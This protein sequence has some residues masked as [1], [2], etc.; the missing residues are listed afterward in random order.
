VGVYLQ[1]QLA[2]LD[3]DL[4]G[5]GGVRYALPLTPS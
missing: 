5:V 1:Q 4:R 2:L 3:G